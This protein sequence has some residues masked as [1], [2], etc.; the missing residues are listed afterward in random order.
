MLQTKVT[1]KNQLEFYQNVYRMQSD[2]KDQLV[3]LD[4]FDT[5]CVVI[6]C[7]GSHY[8]THFDKNIIVLETIRSAKEFG[9][10]KNQFDKLIDNRDG[11][12]LTWPA[13]SISAPVLIF[14][15]SPMLKYLSLEDLCS[16]V[17]VA[18]EK[19]QAVS[20][21]IRHHLFFVDDS[22]L[23]D[24]FYNFCNFKIKNYCVTQFLYDTR[25]LTYSFEL[26]RVQQVE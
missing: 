16:T 1:P 7:C 22:R 26:K 24:R 18:A 21:V 13:L 9:F 14:D 5:D 25:Q 6:D 11:Q 8:R 12:P 3:N 20:I 15:R 10:S 19:Y 17:S 2:S 4:N 23:V